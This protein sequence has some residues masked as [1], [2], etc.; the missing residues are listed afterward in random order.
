MAISEAHVRVSLDK[1]VAEY[2][3]QIK[4][5]VQGDIAALRAAGWVRLEDVVNALRDEDAREEWHQIIGAVPWRPAVIDYLTE[6]FGNHA[7]PE[8]T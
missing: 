1:P 3:A 5:A 2:V 8:T 6:R 4:R 7:T